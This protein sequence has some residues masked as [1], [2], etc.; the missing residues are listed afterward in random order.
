MGTDLGL[1]GAEIV[2]CDG[3]ALLGAQQVVE[4]PPAQQHRVGL[5]R[6]GRRGPR[7][8]LAAGAHTLRAQQLHVTP[9]CGL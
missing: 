9:H 1:H 3:V 4:H 5:R 6:A 7:R 2:G 8:A